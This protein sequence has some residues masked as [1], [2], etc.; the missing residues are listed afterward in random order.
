[1]A[2]THLFELE[3]QPWFP[4]F[5]RDAGTGYISQVVR[6]TGMMSGAAPFLAKALEHTESRQIVDL[7]SGA[8]GPASLMVPAMAEAGHE[9]DVLCTDLFPNAAALQYTADQSNGRVSFHSAPVDATNVPPE[10]QGVRTIFN[11][12][13]HFQPDVARRI[14][15]DAARSGQP[16][17]IFEFVSREPHA[18]AG[19]LGLPVAVMAILPFV[20]PFHWAWIPLTYL[21]PLIPA[22]IVWDGLVSCLR[23]YY[24]DELAELTAGLD[25]YDW[26]FGRFKLPG[27]PGKGTYLVGTPR[28]A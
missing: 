21:V 25:T 24:P 5:M 16:I 1:M 22:F 10:L 3:D 8:G 2:R 9:I 17:A 7:C 14:L 13:H 11:A 18:V 6:L 19:M 28:G 20:R 27:S 4:A 26:D 15:E 12:F 23:I